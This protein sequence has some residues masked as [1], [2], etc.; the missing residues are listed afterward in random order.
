[1][2]CCH[3]P[4]L[5]LARLSFNCMMRCLQFEVPEMIQREDVVKTHRSEV[6]GFANSFVHSLCI[7]HGILKQ[8]D[9]YAISVFIIYRTQ[10][11]LIH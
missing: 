2:H 6:F 11:M 3:V 1:M 4:T 7:L 10:N 5:E 9:W 8:F